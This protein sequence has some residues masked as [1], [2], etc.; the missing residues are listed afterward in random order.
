M[1]SN[2][3]CILLGEDGSGKS[4]IGNFILRRH[5][6]VSGNN[7]GKFIQESESHSV[8]LDNR[9]ITVVDTPGLFD[10]K[11]YLLRRL[12]N[13]Q[14]SLDFAQLGRQFFLLVIKYGKLTETVHHTADLLKI[15]FGPKVLEHTII[16]FTHEDD[17]MV[18]WKNIENLV[19]ELDEKESIQALIDECGRRFITLSNYDL[20]AHL[21]QEKL[22]K[23]IMMADALAINWMGYCEESFNVYRRVLQKY[24]ND[25][26]GEHLSEEQIKI[27]KKEQKQEERKD[28][29]FSNVAGV[30]VGAGIGLLGVVTYAAGP[31]AV[32]ALTAAVPVIAKH[33]K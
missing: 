24:A 31:V 5:A 23:L 1:A 12:I 19:N 17:V 26:K 33:I 16:V 10:T 4:S 8:K 14:S 22:E 27:I 7:P 9:I 20:D 21:G 29:V 25:W 15:M 30:L 18:K 2:I 11:E 3:C 6:F 28:T 13:V 32:G